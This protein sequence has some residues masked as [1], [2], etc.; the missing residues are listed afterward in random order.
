[1]G[2]LSHGKFNA[3]TN[4]ETINDENI[5][6]LH[7]L[8]FAPKHFF[9]SL[10]PAALVFKPGQDWIQIEIIPESGAIE[11]ENVAD[12]AGDHY[13]ITAS[14]RLPKERA[15]IDKQLNKHKGL[16]CLV[17]LLDQNGY[18]RLTGHEL[19]ELL[20]FHSSSSGAAAADPNGYTITFKGKQLNK[21]IFL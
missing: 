7:L 15:V 8:R 17:W 4:L 3:M 12:D 1:M 21:A 5:G 18:E 9:S 16:P 13:N 19:G 10:D 2:H 11:H 14:A 6:G 20:L